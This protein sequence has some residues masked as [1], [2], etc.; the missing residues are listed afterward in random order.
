MLFTG[1]LGDPV[2]HF[3]NRTFLLVSAETLETYHAVLQGEQSIVA[4][5]ADIGAGMDLGPAL[6]VKNVA[7]LNKLSVSPLRAKALGLGITAV[8]GG[9]DALLMS[10]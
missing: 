3:V 5:D 8:L 10:K 4:A 7:G 9:A 6:S 2:S 1:L